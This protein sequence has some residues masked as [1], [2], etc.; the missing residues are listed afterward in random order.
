MQTQLSHM[1]LVP[2]RGVWQLIATLT[3]LGAIIPTAALAADKPS[4]E[5]RIAFA[6]LGA[7]R[8]IPWV[9]VPSGG[10]KQ[11]QISSM[12]TWSAVR[13]MVSSRPTTASPSPGRNQRTSCSGRLSYGQISV[14]R[15]HS[16]H[17]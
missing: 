4:G 10:I 17:R 2:W 16:A 12:I 9:E 5:L 13:M 3:L 6:F 11:Y 1:P 7:Q 15:W 8:M 14:S